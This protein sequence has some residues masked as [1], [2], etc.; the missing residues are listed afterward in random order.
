MPLDSRSMVI[1]GYKFLAM[2]RRSH[3]L[4][5]KLTAENLISGHIEIYTKVKMVMG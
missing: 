3:L 2:G 5:D 4:V 1:G